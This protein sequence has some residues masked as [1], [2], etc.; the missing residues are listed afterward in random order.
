MKASAGCAAAP[1]VRYG[2]F[3]VLP[4][5]Q[6]TDD[7]LSRENRPVCRKGTTRHCLPQSGF[8]FLHI[9]FVRR[10]F[11]FTFNKDF[12]AIRLLPSNTCSKERQQRAVSN[13][14]RLFHR[15]MNESR[16]SI[17][18]QT[19]VICLGVAIGADL[20]IAIGAALDEIGM[21]LCLGNCVGR[22]IGLAVEANRPKTDGDKKH[23][24]RQS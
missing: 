3:G 6:K 13:K 10:R 19:A 5:K 24:D 11:A 21:G 15:R 17:P 16:M 12:A 23:Q 14:S 22:C 9:C 1:T 4:N 7:F 20:G 2:G 18:P 8:I